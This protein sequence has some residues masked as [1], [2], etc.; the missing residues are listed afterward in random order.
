MLSHQ[1]LTCL[2][3]EEFSFS[4]DDF[5]GKTVA[6]KNMILLLTILYDI[7]EDQ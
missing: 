3:N 2:T 6:N 7:R 1:V 5:S 4:F